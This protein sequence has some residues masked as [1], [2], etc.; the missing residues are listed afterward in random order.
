MKAFIDEKG[1][2]LYCYLRKRQKRHAAY[3]GFARFPAIRCQQSAC[4]R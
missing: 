3:F 1:S 4:M 2:P